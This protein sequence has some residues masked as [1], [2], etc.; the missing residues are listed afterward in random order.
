MHEPHHFMDDA[1][2]MQHYNYLQAQLPSHQRQPMP[3]PSSQAPLLRRT[4][5]LP[6]ISH[7]PSWP[8]YYTTESNAHSS[9]SHSG[10]SS[11]STFDSPQCGQ[12]TSNPVT[13]ATDSFHGMQL[14]HR[15]PPPPPHDLHALIHSQPHNSAHHDIAPDRDER[16]SLPYDASRPLEHNSPSSSIRFTDFLQSELTVPEG[17]VDGAGGNARIKLQ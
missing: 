5:A 13:P 10:G 3:Y 12:S 7:S 11:H 16:T 6:S 9:Y 14:S 17:S 2:P 8:M 4:S 1:L 15:L